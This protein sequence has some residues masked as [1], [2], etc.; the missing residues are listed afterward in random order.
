MTG[1]GGLAAA[2][3]ATFTGASAGVAA[4]LDTAEAL[5]TAVAVAAGITLGGG[6]GA[7]AGSVVGVGTTCVIAVVVA[8]IAIA[9]VAAV[10]AEFL[11]GIDVGPPCGFRST[12]NRPSAV[13]TSAASATIAA[14]NFERLG[15]EAIDVLEAST[16]V[17]CPSVRAGTVTVSVPPTAPDLLAAP[18][19]STA[20]WT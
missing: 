3:G 12:A 4:V 11:V 5:V 19:A 18:D 1:V 15:I 6:V 2:L 17:A 16:V 14:G 8:A 13:N 10:V 9:A 7:G 20:C